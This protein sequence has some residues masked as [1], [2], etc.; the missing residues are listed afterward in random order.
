MHYT[1]HL[2]PQQK[3][4]GLLELSHVKSSFGLKTIKMHES[5]VSQ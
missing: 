4:E 2:M 1:F 5:F 3:T